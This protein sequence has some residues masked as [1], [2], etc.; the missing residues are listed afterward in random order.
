MCLR[1][2]VDSEIALKLKLLKSRGK[3]AA[4]LERELGITEGLLTKSRDQYQV[5]EKESELARL[6][7]SELEAARHEIE[8]LE[9]RWA[10]MEEERVI[11]KNSAYL[12][13]ERQM[14]S[15]FIQTHQKTDGAKRLCKILGITRSAYYAQRKRK[16][17]AREREWVILRVVNRIVQ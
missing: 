9:K 6:E 4:Q 16:A 8:R 17:S 14:K 7:R 13:A 12:F 3:S 5:V 10:E 15:E 2:D 1:Q 11:K